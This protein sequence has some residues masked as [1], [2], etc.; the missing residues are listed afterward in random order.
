[1]SFEGRGLVGRLN[2]VSLVAMG[3]LLV[4]ADKM[5][6]ARTLSLNQ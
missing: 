4:Q 2:G 6:Q 5:N 3:L 1:M